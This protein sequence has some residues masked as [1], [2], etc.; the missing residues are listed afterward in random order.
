[1][2]VLSQ[3]GNRSE[4]SRSS[5][6]EF[7]DQLVQWEH[8]EL[9]APAAQA[10]RWAGVRRRSVNLAARALD[11]ATWAD[12]GLEGIA[13]DGHYDLAVV[14][15]EHLWDLATLNRIRGWRDQVAVT[16]LFI[17]E[18][19]VTDLSSPLFTRTAALIDT[20]DHV[21]ISIPGTVGPLDALT[22]ASV[23]PLPFAGDVMRMLPRQLGAQRPLDVAVVGRR[24]TQLDALL[25]EE[26]RAGRL[27]YYADQY[28]A[29]TVVDHQRHRA[30]LYEL[31]RLSKLWLCYPARFDDP[32]RT[33]GQIHAGLRYYEAL[34]GGA[35]PAGGT[36]PGVRTGGGRPIDDM[37]LSLPEDPGAVMSV[38]AA[39]I[40]DRDRIE[41]AEREGVLGAL[42]NE[43]WA[44][45]WLT[46]TEQVGLGS[47]RSAL[48]QVERLEEMARALE[49][50]GR[51]DP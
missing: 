49:L 33:D 31:V 17:A 39:A 41:H 16:V 26:R 5:L 46:L 10:G 1:M 7:E 48:G 11:R 6:Y 25:S 3:R 34:A 28:A 22:T 36:V 23:N 12:P 44:H 8:A 40:S 13:L 30:S 20:F 2:L 27:R 43:D 18:L 32:E 50:T 4:A 35:T 19:W 45:R 21:F 9:F 24:P 37:M 38:V 51:C 14:T 15:A 29:P 47:S 42:R